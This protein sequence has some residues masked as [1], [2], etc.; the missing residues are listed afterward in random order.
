MATVLNLHPLSRLEHALGE[1]SGE[2]WD[3]VRPW[4]GHRHIL[5]QC[6]SFMFNVT[7]FF[8][9]LLLS[10]LAFSF[11]SHF[12]PVPFLSR[13]FFFLPPSFLPSLHPLPSPT[14]QAGSLRSSH[15]H[16]PCSPVLAKV[17]ISP[18][19]PMIRVLHKRLYSKIRPVWANQNF[20][21]SF[22]VFSGL[23][24]PYRNTSVSQIDAPHVT[25]CWDSAC[26][27]CRF[28][29]RPRVPRPQRFHHLSD[30]RMLA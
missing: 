5:S 3:I 1:N 14:W 2:I 12:S 19:V 29:C 13:T 30:S 4:F 15:A 16:R 25:G 11:P 27:V 28:K 17:P 20:R 21:G 23:T 26:A 18:F 22:S 6:T 8:H 7:S 9:F 24:K 10:P